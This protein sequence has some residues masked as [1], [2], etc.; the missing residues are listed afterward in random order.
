M[1]KILAMLLA[2]MMLLSVASV[3]MAETTTIATDAFK[4]VYNLTNPGT[5]SPEERFAFTLTCTGVTDAKEGITENDAPTLTA[6]IDPMT[7]GN[8]KNISLSAD[9]AFPSIGWYTYTITETAGTT[10][11][12]TYDTTVR[13]LKVLVVNDDE[14]GLRIESVGAVKNSDNMKDDTFTNVY[15][16][17]TLSIKKQVTGNLGDKDKYFTV[18][19]TLTGENG[20]TYANSYAVT[21]GKYT[22]GETIKVG[23]PKIFELKNGDTITIAN[24]PYGVTYTVVENDYTGDNG[25]YDAATYTGDTGENAKIDGAT[26]NVTI[27]NNKDGSIDMGV[28]LDSMPYVLVLAVVGAAVIA[29]IA[30]KRRAE[31]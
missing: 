17:G 11:G 28:M 4:K 27:T 24:L 6:T 21:G 14:N 5:S 16:A 2:V 25:G 9:K 1:K 22:A 10:A 18:T 19:V 31:D 29:L 20:K 13:T 23:E 3:A 7:A 12:V 26:Q 30:K 15:S 8:T